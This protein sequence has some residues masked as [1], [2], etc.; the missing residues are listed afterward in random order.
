MKPPNYTSIPATMVLWLTAGFCLFNSYAFGDVSV[1][2]KPSSAEEQNEARPGEPF[3]LHLG[4]GV[5]LELLWV[6]PGVFHM[7][8]PANEA[9]RDDD[10]PAFQATLCHGY[11]LGRFEVTQA[12]WS[13]VMGTN[14][15]EFSELGPDAPVENVSWEDAMRFCRRVT[16]RER[17]WQRIPSQYS[18]RLPTEAQWEYACRAGTT[19]AYAW[20]NRFP[21]GICNAENSEGTG[22]DG[23]VATFH[24]QGRPVSS[25]MPVGTFEPNAWGFYDMHGNVW[26]WCHDWY[27][28][29]PAKP[30]TEPNGPDTGEIKV[31]RGGSWFSGKG[32]CRSANRDWGD[33]GNR[34]HD[35]GFRLALTHD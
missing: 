18:F 22:E 16:R 13:V 15:S 9:G 8:S 19:T 14:P 27:A 28:D 25:S 35:L 34:Y 29:Y 2:G 6:E 17:A 1:S 12:Q 21:E 20:G 23:N 31:L 4:D 10:E 26:E 33:P 24:K 30:E 11:W 3:L 7:S 5:T 32:R